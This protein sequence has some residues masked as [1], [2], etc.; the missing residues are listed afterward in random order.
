MLQEDL[1]QIMPMVNE[2]NAMA[3]ELGKKVPNPVSPLVHRP[4][5]PL[6]PS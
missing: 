6:S 5:I 1:V 4:P 2:A 3:E